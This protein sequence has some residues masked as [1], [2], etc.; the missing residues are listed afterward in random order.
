MPKLILQVRT[1]D[2]LLDLLAASESGD[3]V[4]AKDQTQKIT[5]VQ[6]VNWSGTQMIEGIFDRD[7][8]YRTE[9]DRLVIKFLDGHIINCS[10]QFKGQ[11]PVCYP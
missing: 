4:V 5:H 7:N 3:W 6:V 11:N 9:N 10:V 2:N 8:S 1:K